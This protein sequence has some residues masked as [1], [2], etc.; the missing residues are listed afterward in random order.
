MAA[1]KFQCQCKDWAQHVS[2]L[3]RVD[4]IWQYGLQRR[5]VDEGAAKHHGNL[6]ILF[7]EKH[8]DR[9]PLHVWHG[10]EGS[11][12]SRTRKVNVLF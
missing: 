2:T 7:G 4:H 12:D 9:R 11:T 5:I 3:D 6:G 1:L 8:R 10:V